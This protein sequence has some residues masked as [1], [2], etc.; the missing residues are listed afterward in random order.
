MQP[1][2]NQ[3]LIGLAAVILIVLIFPSICPNTQAQTA[4]TFTPSDR[5]SIPEL[6]GTISFAVNGSCSSA[7]L[8]NGTWTFNDLRFNI[9]HPLGNLKVSAENS[10]LT[11]LSYRSY[12]LF[13]R[14]AQLRYNVQG[15]G[16][17]TVNLGLNSSQPTHPSEWSISV[18]GNVFLAEGNGWNLLPDDSVV[19]SG[20]TGNVSVT[21]YGFVVP[22]D[23]NLPFY[24]QHSIIIIAAIV[25]SVIV[26][27]AVIIRVKVRS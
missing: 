25:L 5:F 19:V 13:G 17:Q 7:T 24:Q 4:T 20:L 21:H 12:N 6:N 16:T 9:S 22:N 3:T 8:E 18:L 10:N 23:G 27:I 14:S 15:V 2:A 26:A 11:I 1:T